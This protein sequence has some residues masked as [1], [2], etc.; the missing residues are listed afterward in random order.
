MDNKNIV[1]K[2]I[3]APPED[4]T[5]LCSYATREEGFIDII[6]SGCIL[7]SEEAYRLLGKITTHWQLMGW[8]KGIDARNDYISFSTGFVSFKYSDMNIKSIDVYQGGFGVF[9]RLD[10]LLGCKNI[11]FSNCAD[12]SGLGI[13]SNLDTGNISDLFHIVRSKEWLCDDGYGNVFEIS[14]AAEKYEGNIIYPRLELDCDTIIAAPLSEK[15]RIMKKIDERQKYYRELLKNIK[16]QS[17]EEKSHL[18]I[19]DRVIFNTKETIGFIENMLK[20]FNE[21]KINIFWYDCKN[22]DIALKYKS[23]RNLER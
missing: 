20:P 2:Y 10:K 14:L 3:C 19:E 18:F 12:F 6:L 15:D 23:M 1:E 11:M 9:A 21:R 16:E 22:L 17:N 5:P 4:I 13:K 7:S 8:P